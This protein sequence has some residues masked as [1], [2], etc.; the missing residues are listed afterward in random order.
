MSKKV[1]NIKDNVM[2]KMSSA[3]QLSRAHR[4]NVGWNSPKSLS[5]AVEKNQAL[6][7]VM[8]AP[9]SKADSIITG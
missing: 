3:R 7:S 6:L 4:G 9:Q 8:A 2:V 5:G 1:P